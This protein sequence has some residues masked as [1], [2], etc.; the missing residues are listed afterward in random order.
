MK[1]I[2]AILLILSI[3]SISAQQIFPLNTSKIDYSNGDYYKDLDGELNP[4]TGTW[5]G[6]WEGK[7]LYLELRKI[8]KRF[9]STSGNYFDSDQIVGE[10]KVISSAG[11]VEVDRIIGFDE[12]ASEFLGIFG[13]YNN[14]SQK[15]LLF[16]PRN[17]CNATANVNVTFSNAE[18]TQLILHFQENPGILTESCH[19]YNQ[20]A[21]GKGFPFNFPKDIVLTKQ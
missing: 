19:L 6:T 8:K 1:K 7:T 16:Q 14:F 5:K 21:D 4:Y 3:N 18:K 11:A 9:T 2:L 15:Y 20:L 10:R 17:M 13:Q 12:S